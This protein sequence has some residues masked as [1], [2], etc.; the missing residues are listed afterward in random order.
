MGRYTKEDVIRLVEEEDVEF[1]RLQFSDIFGSLKNVAIT[2][3]QLERALDNKC[4]FDGS[5]IDGFSRIEESDM[6]LRPD[7]DTFEIFPW[8]PQQGKVARLICDVYTANQQPFKADSRYILKKVLNRAKSLGYSFD[9]GP[10]CEFF[11]FDTDD[12]GR[13]TTN[14]NEQAGFFDVSPVD[15]GENVR[16]DI[17]LNLEDMGFEVES[18]YH[19]IAPAQHEIDF[20]YG[21]A[22][23]TADNIMTFRMAV[24]TIASRHGLYATFLPK[25]RADVNGSGMHI[26]MSLRNADG[27]NVFSDISDENGIS[28]IAYHFIAGLMKHIKAITAITNPL[29]NSYKRLVAGYEAPTDIVW[30]VKNRSTLIRIPAALSPQ[31][32]RVELRSPD[33]V[34]NPYLAFA[35][36]LAAGLDG[37]ENKL[38]PP[39]EVDC[40]LFEMTEKQRKKLGIDQLPGSLPEAIECLKSDEVIKDVLGEYIV[41]RYTA[42]KKDEWHDYHSQ[43]TRWEINNYLYKF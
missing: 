29:V 42:A 20:K 23:A 27:V 35:V 28:K 21:E 41:E 13:P 14:T 36:C 16:R 26:N 6:C 10:E 34:S 1:I 3:S 38:E 33:G 37:I 30:S 31:N 4:T 25:P 9:V 2:S 19:E 40:N 32:A 17:V 22:L 8:R 18:S 43:I 12:L 39:A 24:K 15:M 11:L 5:A 7:L